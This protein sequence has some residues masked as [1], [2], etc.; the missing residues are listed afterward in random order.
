MGFYPS[1][2]SLEDLLKSCGLK[3]LQDEI[4]F[5]LFARATALMLEENNQYVRQQIA[6]NQEEY[7]EDEEHEDY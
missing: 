6:G 4:T 5:E 3:D 1:D 2:E 7:E